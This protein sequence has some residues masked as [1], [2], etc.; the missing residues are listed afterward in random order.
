MA[1]TLVSAVAHHDTV[2]PA[3]ADLEVALLTG[4]KDR[5]YAFGLAMALTAN[6]VTVE[7]VGSDDLDSPELHRTARLQFLSLQ[8]RKVDTGLAR[9]WK[10]LAYYGRL[11]SHA[12]TSRANVFHVLWNNRLEYVDR[13]LLML[14]YKAQGRKVVLT[15]HNVNQRKRDSNDSFFNRLTLKSQYRLVDHIFVHTQKMKQELTEDFRVPEEAVTVLRHPINDAFPDTSL[16]PA[17]AKQ[18]LGIKESERTLLFLGRITPYKGLEYLLEAFHQLGARDD[19]YRL[20][21]AG[22]TKKGTEQYSQ[23]IER[24]IRTAGRGERIIFDNQFIPDE[25]MELYLKAADVL[26]LPYTDI[27]QSGVLFLGF[28]FGLPAIASDVGSFREDVVENRT[29]LLFRPRD[30]VDLAR[31][32]ET[33]FTSDLYNHLSER[34]DDIRKYFRQHHSWDAVARATRHVYAQLMRH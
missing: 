4:C 20:I 10:L 1:S 31:A 29:G 27:F 33:Y 19:S 25:K 13:T 22:Q 17:E 28:T 34:R 23:D 7:F 16:T 2:I 8:G 24:L 21:I 32:I 15:A 30:S 5:P 6:D 18:R 12:V 26:V 11:V 14:L 3:P 9:V